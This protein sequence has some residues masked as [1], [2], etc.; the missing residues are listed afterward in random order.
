MD[1]MR[2]KPTSRKQKLQIVRSSVK[3]ENGFMRDCVGVS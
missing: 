3:E 1:R 2:R